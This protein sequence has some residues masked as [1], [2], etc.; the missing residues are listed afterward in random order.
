MSR[1]PVL[2]LGAGSPAL[3][4]LSFPVVDGQGFAL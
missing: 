1:T 4:V 2:G 3:N